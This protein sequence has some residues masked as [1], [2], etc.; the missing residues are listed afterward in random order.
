MQQRV[1]KVTIRK[2][3]QEGDKEVPFDSPFVEVGVGEY[4]NR[5]ERKDEPFTL[6]G[7]RE[8]TAVLGSK[9]F[10]VVEGSES[11]EEVERKPKAAPAE[12]QASATPDP[13]EQSGGEVAA[14]K[15]G[16]ADQP[17]ASQAA[18][19]TTRTRT[20]AKEQ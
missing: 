18:P 2:T 8:I 7:E 20:R 15:G 12:A 1:L 3:Q 6:R 10:E 19:A 4:H 16:E 14:T 5:F 11:F 13:P 9:R 17:D